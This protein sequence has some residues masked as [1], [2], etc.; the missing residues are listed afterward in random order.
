MNSDFLHH[1][2]AWNVENLRSE[3][4][5]W[6]EPSR[7][8]RGAC[9]KSEKSMKVAQ[10][11]N[12]ILEAQGITLAAGITGQAIRHS[13]DELAKEPH[14]TVYHMRQERVAIDAAYVPVASIAR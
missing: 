14:A 11:I 7:Q 10:A 6:V 3:G 1:R 12:R 2:P 9:R 13:A 4:H 5:P 8:V